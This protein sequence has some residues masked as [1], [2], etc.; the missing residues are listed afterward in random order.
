MK[1]ITGAD[2]LNLI[3]RHEVAYYA[4]DRALIATVT[5]AGRDE[6]VWEPLHAVEESGLTV[7]ASIGEKRV[8]VRRFSYLVVRE[9]A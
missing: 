5:A 4:D 1:S 6:V 9:V 7:I 3:G 8:P 2:L